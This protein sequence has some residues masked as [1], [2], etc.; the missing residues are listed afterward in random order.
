MNDEMK[1]LA[2]RAVA[3]KH[4]RW[5]PGMKA[6][7]GD[8]PAPVRILATDDRCTPPEIEFAWQWCS[9]DGCSSAWFLPDFTDAAT[10]G[11]L[12]AL[13]REAAQVPVWVAPETEPDSF[14]DTEHVITNQPSWIV[15]IQ[16]YGC[17]VECLACGD[18]E[19]AAL[20]AALEAAE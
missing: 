1:A 16:R 18:T 9:G 8:Y 5:M 11:C 15:W 17:F 12:L 6:F 2:T 20:V 19:A 14:D 13:V 10:L 4:W 7:H 3:C